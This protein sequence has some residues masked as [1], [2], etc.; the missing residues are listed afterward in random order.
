MYTVA[1]HTAIKTRM[2]WHWYLYRA[3]K[4]SLKLGRASVGF[5]DGIVIR[6]VLEALLAEGEAGNTTLAALAATLKANMRARQQS[7]ASKPYP[8][9]SEFGCTA[10][11]AAKL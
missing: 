4:T 2:P 7:F 11:A 3:A 6:E 8:Y 9:G 1:R 10:Y 5:M